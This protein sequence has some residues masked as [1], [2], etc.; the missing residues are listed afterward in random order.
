MLAKVDEFQRFP[1]TSFGTVRLFQKYTFVQT[2]HFFKTFSAWKK[3]L[4]NF[5]GF[6]LGFLAMRLFPEEKIR[7]VFDVSTSQNVVFE[8]YGY[9]FG[10][11]V[12]LST[13]CSTCMFN[14]LE[15]REMLLRNLGDRMARLIERHNCRITDQKTY[16]TTAN[17]HV[18]NSF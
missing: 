9:P 3:R 12:A 1:F 8:S 4:W 17:R 10:H 13:S 16:Q 14:Q 15:Y 7:D 5:K 6:I 11:F 18:I 2:L